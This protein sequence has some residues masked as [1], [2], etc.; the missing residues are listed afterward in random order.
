MITAFTPLLLARGR[1]PV[2]LL[3]ST[4]TPY[5]YS[6]GVGSSASYTGGY[7]VANGYQPTIAHTTSVSGSGGDVYNLNWEFNSAANEA[8]GSDT[9]SFTVLLCWETKGWPGRLTTRSPSA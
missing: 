5:T 2:A 1:R 8:P 4:I 6:G 7:T 9:G 3:P